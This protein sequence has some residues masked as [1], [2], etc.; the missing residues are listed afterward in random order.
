MARADFLTSLIFLALGVYMAVE[1]LRMPG[2]GG[3]IV[4]GGEPGRVPVM[5]GVIIALLAIILLVRA[6]RQGGH[7]LAG[8]RLAD[9][10]L[11]SGAIR[12]GV[13]AA[14]CS[15]YAVGMIGA[16]LWGHEVQYAA[17]TFLFLAVFIVGS[18]WGFAQELAL[19]RRERW[20]R[21]TPRLARAVQSVL[22][23]VPAA[24]APYVWLVALALIQ[25]ALVSWTVAYVFES[26]FYVKLP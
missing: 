24:Y 13:T 14:F 17:A 2:A 23:F 1:G 16:T 19:Q 4:K 21:R 12:C 8:I 7:R 20:M 15:F 6:V 11:R 3:F 26:Q 18:E 25:A 9:P 10:D 5:L 22:G